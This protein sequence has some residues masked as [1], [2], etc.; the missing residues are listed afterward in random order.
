MSFEPDPLVVDR[1]GVGKMLKVSPR[2]VSRLYDSGK[3]PEP[4]ELGGCKRWSIEES[5]SWVRAGGPPRREWQNLRSAL[6]AP[7]A[8]EAGQH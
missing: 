1:E 2:Q 4:L 7:R 5:E 8:G 3:L 6:A